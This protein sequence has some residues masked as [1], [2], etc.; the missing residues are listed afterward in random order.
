MSENYFRLSASLSYYTIFSLAPLLLITISL[1]GFFFGRQAMEGKVFS[2]M[3]KY[4]GDAA[5]IQAQQM[6]RHIA[7]TQNSFVAKI[8][9]LIVMVI[10]IA[11]VFAEVQD[12]VNHIW[13]LKSIRKLNRIKYFIKRSVSL[14]FFSIIGFILVLS[15]IVS[16]LINVLGN[17]LEVFVNAGVYMV[18]VIDRIIIITIVAMLFTLILKYLPDGKVKWTDAIKGAIFTSV[19]FMFGQAIIGYFLSHLN[20]SSAFGAAGSLVILLLWIYYS[21]VI[22]YFGVT[23]TKVYAYL[24]GGKITPSSF[25]IF[26]KNVPRNFPA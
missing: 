2:E 17:Y 12:A 19:F 24:Y 16:L 8:A 15:L 13:G 7:L 22:I 20:V 25:A 23:F 5:A 26:E 9:G 1:F 3:R 14:A 4:I 10:G 11:A 6:I 21:S 18:F